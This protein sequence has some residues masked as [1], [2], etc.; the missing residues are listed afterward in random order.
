MEERICWYAGLLFWLGPLDLG[1]VC[2][3]LLSFIAI[4]VQSEG[5]Y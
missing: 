4:L 2:Y 5:L 3:S 1:A